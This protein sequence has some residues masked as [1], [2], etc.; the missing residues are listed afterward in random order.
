MAIDR[1]SFDTLNTTFIP[2][3]QD[4]RITARSGLIFDA[5]R[6][7]ARTFDKLVGCFPQ[8][9]QRL[10]VDCAPDDRK[11]VTI[12]LFYLC[13]PERSTIQSTRGRLLKAVRSAGYRRWLG[14]DYTWIDWEQ[15]NETDN[16]AETLLFRDFLGLK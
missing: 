3:N 16:L 7:T 4:G 8:S 14:I 6:H 5:F 10:R 13:A 2:Y 15:C 12:E 9:T 1:A 11:A